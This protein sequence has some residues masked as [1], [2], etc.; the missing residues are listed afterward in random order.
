MILQ[1]LPTPNIW[2]AVYT[3]STKSK[4]Y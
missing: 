2:T 1:I 4:M 3:C